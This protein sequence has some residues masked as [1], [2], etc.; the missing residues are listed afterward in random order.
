MTA[1]DG[2][3][4][5]ENLARLALMYLIA[6]CVSPPLS[7]GM[8]YRLAAIA[9]LLFFSLMLFRKLDRRIGGTVLTAAFLIVYMIVLSLFT[10]DSFSIRI[11]TYILILLLLCLLYLEKVPHI[12]DYEILIVFIF[13][14]CTVWNVT[15][16][17]EMD[18]N[19]NIMRE[20]AKNSADAIFYAKHG[21]GGYG[22]IYT[23]LVLIPIAI[24]VL[25]TRWDRKWM[26]WSSL[27]FL[28]TAYAMLFSAAYFLAIL[29]GIMIVPL[30]FTMRIQNQ[31]ERIIILLFLLIL[32]VVLLSTATTLILT[33]LDWIDIRSIQNKLI[34]IY[35]LL[36]DEETIEGSEFAVRYTRYTNSFNYAI[37]HPI[38]GGFSYSVTGKHS[39]VLDFAAQYGIP[40][41]AAYLYVLFRPLRSIGAWKNA[42][43]L[44]SVVATIIILLLNSAPFSMGAVLFIILPIHSLGQREREMSQESRKKDEVEA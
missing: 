16:L 33:L 27:V 42:G 9:V 8:Q 29:L 12:A 7:Y 13:L 1:L 22:Y 21:V 17:R 4:K 5:T 11:G 25:F 20:L 39:H 30:Y 3:L 23:V 31:L 6:W 38:L 26:W 44:V 28:A 37:T 2:L 35:Q 32:F 15:S 43:S 19:A 18:V 40:L 10:G 34:S 36:T 24:D 41:A 14:L